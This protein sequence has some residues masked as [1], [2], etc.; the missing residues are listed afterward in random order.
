MKLD[1]HAHAGKQ[2]QRQQGTETV[3]PKEGS[4]IDTARHRHQI[5]YTGRGKGVNN[6]ARAK[7]IRE[8][9]E[10]WRKLSD[11]SKLAEAELN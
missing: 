5:T 1:E 2:D 9:G 10:E 11:R 4:H 7:E 3:K 6:T 8:E